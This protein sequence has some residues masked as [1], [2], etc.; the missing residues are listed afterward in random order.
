MI[1]LPPGGRENA[2]PDTVIMGLAGPKVFPPMTNAEDE[3]A[4]YATSPKLIIGES[5]I[6]GAWLKG[7]D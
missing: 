1:W 6:V 5:E 2:V 3:V 7:E 4:V